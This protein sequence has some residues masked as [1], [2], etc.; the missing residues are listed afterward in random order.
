MWP[1]PASKIPPKRKYS[2]PKLF[3]LSSKLSSHKTPGEVFGIVWDA[4]HFWRIEHPDR[5]YRLRTL[6]AEKKQAISTRIKISHLKAMVGLKSRAVGASM[7]G[8]S[9]QEPISWLIN[10]SMDTFTNFSFSLDFQRS[11]IKGRFIFEALLTVLIGS[12]WVNVT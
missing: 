9:V 6:N 7:W 4:V 11:N 3:L 2:K 12:N 8:F 1:S 10:D 5:V